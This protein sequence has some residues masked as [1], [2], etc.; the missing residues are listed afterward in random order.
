[1]S[2]EIAWIACGIAAA[3]LAAGLA[4]YDAVLVRPLRARLAAT[5]ARLEAL[6]R[7]VTAAAG[8]A[9][10]VARAERVSAERLETLDGR[11]GRLELRG[12]SRGLEQ[13]IEAA[14]GGAFEPGAAD[15][16]LNEGEASLVRLLHGKLH[17]G[18][19]A[20]ATR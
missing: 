5:A 11:L 15:F 6:E 2:S 19:S 8:L 10:R 18:A 7:A 16:G 20:R 17:G 1:M 14:A 4:V 12:Y 13:A 9:G 3:A